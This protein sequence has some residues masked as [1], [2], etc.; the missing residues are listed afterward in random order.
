MVAVLAISGAPAQRALMQP[1]STLKQ[2]GASASMSPDNRREA[3]RAKHPKA[4]KAE[5]EKFAS[6]VDKKYA[7]F[8]FK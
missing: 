5:I 2:G 4:R 6:G 1:A 8:W 7:K 3:F